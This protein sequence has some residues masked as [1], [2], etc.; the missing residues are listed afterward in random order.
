[1][2]SKK[3]TSAPFGLNADLIV[4]TIS[5]LLM[6][7]S[8]ASAAG[9]YSSAPKEFVVISKVQRNEGVFQYVRRTGNGTFNHALYQQIIGAA[10][11]FKEGDA[12]VGVA[13]RDQKTRLLARQLLAETTIRELH[14]TPLFQDVQ[15]ALLWSDIDNS[16]YQRIQ[17]WNIGDLKRFLLTRPE[18]EIKTIMPGLNSDVIA[19]VVKLMN[20]A[21]LIRAG[22]TVFNP[23]PGGNI[24]A[25]GYMGARIQPNSPTD[26]SEEIIWQVFNGFSFAVGDVLLG[27]NPV[28]SAPD[29]VKAVE[30]ALKDVVE[31]FGLKG[32][33]PWSVLAHI[34]VQNQVE[35]N[36]PGSTDLF[37]QSIAGVEN[38]NK[39]FDISVSKMMAYAAGRTGTFGLYFETGQGADF[40]NG[41][42]HGFDMVVHEARK[43]GFARAMK[44]KI[45]S[46]KTDGRGAWVILNDV[47]GFIGPEVFRTKEQLVR[48]CLEDIVMGKL[49]GLA[50]GLDICTTLHMSVSLDDLEWCQDQIMPANPAYLMALPTRNDPML[51]YLTTSFQDHVRIREKFGYKVNDAMWSFFKKIEV[52]DRDG[53]PTVHFGDS[54]WVYYQYRK[55]KGDPRSQ[56]E[57]YTEGRRI[58][59]S[60]KARGV[61]LAI[62][63]GTTAW[64]MEPGLNR[65]IHALYDDAKKSLIMELS[66]EFI[67]TVPDAVVL[68]SSAKNRDEYIGRPVTG[69]H[70]DAESL[71]RLKKL[72]KEWRERNLDPDVVIVLSD[73]LNARALMDKGHFTPYYQALRT[74][75]A[76]KGFRTAP[77]NLVVIGGRVR[78]GYR[79]G[80]LLFADN[81]NEAAR[82]AVIHI[83]GERPGNGHQTFSAYIVTPQVKMWSQAGIVDHN[84]AKVVSGISD[85]TLDPRAAAVETV[86]LLIGEA[87]KP[88]LPQGSL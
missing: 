21:E 47:A 58:I 79:I 40:T 72:R 57:I 53:K 30:L 20:N 46:V 14:E 11:E 77:E 52:I 17:G 16:A 78:A 87:P 26:N 76:Q 65:E 39:T 83:I 25:R 18:H 48:T 68:K 86:S 19:C 66:P 51:S 55:L 63:H 4:L 56:E 31:T 49:H 41:H 64:E 33:L 67:R 88:L 43:Y 84:H 60:V 69:E 42:D 28:D 54:I 85:T 35:K 23:L 6:V 61:P 7:S 74:E 34:D 73:G 13:A 10:N 36:H 50:I 2:L 32:T 82:K 1:M 27:T 70:L 15:Q 5:I 12:A 62:G 8:V 59:Q 71:V 3:T 75:L 38:A 45:A 24:G 81:G 37:F 80:E 22:Q 29:S 44:Q 9:E